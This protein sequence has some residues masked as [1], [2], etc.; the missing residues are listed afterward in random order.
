MDAAMP[1]GCSNGGTCDGS[2]GKAVCKCTQHW[3]GPWCN[4][5]MRKYSYTP[6]KVGPDGST[7]KFKKKKR[8]HFVKAIFSLIIM[9]EIK[10]NGSSDL[11]GTI[12]QNG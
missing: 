8:F 1:N 7:I 9:F 12:G 4:T 6:K 10:K 11:S 3:Q 2:S 5:P